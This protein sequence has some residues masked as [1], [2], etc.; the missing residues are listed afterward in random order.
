MSSL[1]LLSLHLLYCCLPLFAR[2]S[3]SGTIALF[4]DFVCEQA[5]IINPTVDLA[6]NVCL[7]TD[8][9]TG[10]AVEVLPPCASGEATLQLYQDTSCANQID[11]NIDYENCYVPPAAV[12]F[13]C[14]A[15]AKG[16]RATATSTVS[17]G[18]SSMAIA[19]GDPASP[20]GSSPGDSN[21]LNTPSTNE[22]AATSST[23][24]NPTSTAPT[25]TDVK[26]ASAAGSGGLSQS[27]Q[28]GLGVGLPV[29]SI[30]VALLAWL[31]PCTR[32][33][34]RR[35]RPGGANSRRANAISLLGH[36]AEK[37]YEMWNS[38]QGL[39]TPTPP[40]YSNTQQGSG[41]TSTQGF[42]T[43]LINSNTQLG[44]GGNSM[45]GFPP[46]QGNSNGMTGL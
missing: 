31:C 11:A 28:I 33:V 35:H 27:S 32:K 9:A 3:P 16:S 24:S 41:G 17:A 18:S 2:A 1:F 12:L 7:V 44:F 6:A 14:T 38:T 37:G 34:V 8:G 46:T 26:K 40:A 23:T 19:T 29:G 22:A 10:V 4:L 42:P 39:A 43:P 30:V 36:Q 20:T 15:V 13:A 45:P 25:T 21:P 5:S